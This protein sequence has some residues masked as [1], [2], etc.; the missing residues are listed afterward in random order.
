MI[1]LWVAFALQA[2]GDSISLN[3]A[4]D[5][6]RH[7]RGSV[8]AAA[9]GVAEARSALRVAGAITNPIVSYSHSEATPRN[10]LLVEI[11]H[12]GGRC[13]REFF[14][15]GQAALVDVLLQ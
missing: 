9:A 13:R 15:I 6:A 2:P 11:I 1:L 7:A 4:L 10:H 14:L 5:R 3:Q 8:T 12:F